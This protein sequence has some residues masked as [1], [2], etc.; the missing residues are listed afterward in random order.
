MKTGILEILTSWINQR[1]TSKLA[2][3]SRV[4]SSYNTAQGLIKSLCEQVS[5]PEFDILNKGVEDK[6]ARR[7]QKIQNEL[8]DRIVNLKNIQSQLGIK[9]ERLIKASDS[10]RIGK[11]RYEGKMKKSLGMERSKLPQLNDKDIKGVLDLAK[12]CGMGYESVK[13]PIKSLLPSQK[14]I[15]KAKVNDMLKK[16]TGLPSDNYL[17]DQEGYLLDRHHR[18]AAMLELD[19]D[20]EVECIQFDSPVQDIV[21]MI[22]NTT[23]TDEIEKFVKALSFV[24]LDNIAR[25]VIDPSNNKDLRQ[26]AAQYVTKTIT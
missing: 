14:A 17:I 5:G 8:F 16:A 12:S 11:M 24:P 23:E 26:I 20:A 9:Y 21:D 1:T 15:D 13:K 18:W 19:P 7:A 4:L 3:A 22:N 10:T 25:F 6:A 2:Q